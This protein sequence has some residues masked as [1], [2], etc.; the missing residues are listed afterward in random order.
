[1][2]NDFTIFHN[3]IV[4]VTKDI[5]CRHI[6]GT[7]IEDGKIIVIFSLLKKCEVYSVM[8]SSRKFYAYFL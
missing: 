3:S 6:F 5:N 1:M 2:H 8:I 7:L 4:I